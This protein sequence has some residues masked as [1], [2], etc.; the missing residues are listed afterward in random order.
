MRFYYDRLISYSSR[1]V[2]TMHYMI[3]DDYDIYLFTLDNQEMGVRA[4]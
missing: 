3:N 2:I 1:K 4:L